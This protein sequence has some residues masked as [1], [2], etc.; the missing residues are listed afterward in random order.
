MKTIKTTILV[1]YTLSCFAPN[2]VEISFYKKAKEQRTKAL[3][4]HIDIIENMKK[5]L[6]YIKEHEG[7]RL[8]PYNCPAGIKTIGFGHVIQKDEN[9]TCITSKQALNILYNDFIRWDCKLKG[10]S[11]TGKQKN[12]LRHFLFAVGPGNFDNS[13][14]YDQIKR[15]QKPTN[16]LKICNY[17]VNGE[18]VYS[19]KMYQMRKKELE[20]WD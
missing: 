14:V 20:S 4:N 12:A 17:R 10:L 6:D 3:K 19:N 11:I 9:L 8:N 7:L 2:D 16:L 13:K 18:L 15:G 1:L 5:W